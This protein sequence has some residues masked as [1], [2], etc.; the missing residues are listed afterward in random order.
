MSDS[1]TV[2][3]RKFAAMRANT[4]A[5]QMLMFLTRLGH[6][7]KMIVCG[8]ATQIDLDGEVRSGLTDAMEKLAGIRGIGMIELKRGDIVRHRLVQ[9]IVDAYGPADE[10]SNEAGE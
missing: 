7:S 8:D 4:T 2:N 10:S 9:N 5:A 3:T 6:N 1:P